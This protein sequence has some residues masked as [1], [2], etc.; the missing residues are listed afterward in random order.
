MEARSGAKPTMPPQSRSSR[1]SARAGPSER[2]TG[3]D[4]AES[5]SSAAGLDRADRRSH[6]T[7]HI[8]TSFYMRDELPIEVR[9]FPVLCHQVPVRPTFD[10]VALLDDQDHVGAHDRAE[11]VGDDESGTA[12][13]QFFERALDDLFGGG[14]DGAGGFIEH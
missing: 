11:P 5:R 7:Y 8:G 1:Q 13:E 6:Q 9:V 2:P 4:V 3:Y 14:V 10:D 12:F